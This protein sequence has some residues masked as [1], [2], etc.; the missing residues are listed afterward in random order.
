YDVRVVTGDGARVRTTSGIEIGPDGAFADLPAALDTVL[1]VGG[2]GTR[3]LLDD[4][5]H[6]DALGELSQ[7]SRRTTSVCTGALLLGAAGLLDGHRAT[8][9]WHSCELLARIAPL[10]TVLPDQI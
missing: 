10:A 4:R 7:R 1:V 3:P 9:H 5:A 8:T 6:L 2:R